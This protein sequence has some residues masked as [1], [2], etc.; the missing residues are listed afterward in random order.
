LRGAVVGQARGT[1]PAVT[2]CSKYATKS[3]ALLFD[4]S[5]LIPFKIPAGTAY[6]RGT[7]GVLWS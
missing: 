6:S 5:E 4:G 2:T 1:G 3:G 7:L